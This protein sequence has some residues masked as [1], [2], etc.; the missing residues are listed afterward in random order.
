MN[1]L[2]DR[3]QR[4]IPELDDYVYNIGNR[5]DNLWLRF[6][7]LLQGAFCAAVGGGL[8]FV[9]GACTGVSRTSDLLFG[10]VVYK[11]MPDGRWKWPEPG[12]SG[13]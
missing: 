6:M 2:D 1:P 9:V 11:I 5:P 13:E 8:T 12:T 4:L 3:H 10:A 7:V